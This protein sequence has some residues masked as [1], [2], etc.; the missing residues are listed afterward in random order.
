MRQGAF[1]G[2]R[3]EKARLYNGY[4]IKELAEKIECSRQTISGYENG[5]ESNPDF[6]IINKLSE[7]LDF[8]VQFFYEHSLDYKIGSTYFRAQL[9]TKGRYRKQQVEKMALMSAV[10]SFIG[11]YINFPK[12]E[13]LHFDTAETPEE[14]AM[15]L[16]SH[17][18]LGEKPIDNIVFMA[19]SKGIVVTKFVSESSTIDACSQMVNVGDDC[20]FLIGYSDNKQSAARIHFD[21]AHELG[22][23]LMHEFCEDVDA[24]TKDEFRERETE[25]HAF[26]AAFLL[27]KNSF[28]RDIVNLPF[29]IPHY[30]QLKRKWK[31]SIAAMARRAHGLGVVSY[32]EYQ[33]MM[34]TLQRRGLRKDEPLDDELTTSSPKLLRSAIQML[35]NENVFTARE[36][37]DEMSYSHNLTLT[38]NKI[39]ELLNLPKGTLH[40]EPLSHKLRLLK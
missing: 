38:P 20:V 40:F 14:L 29:T 19:E 35:L 22:H 17:W 3:L 33:N 34:R 6:N 31:T 24:L 32:D 12:F 1:N 7:L 10:Y 4:T 18:G 21:I 30:T 26:A 27:P 23:I 11:K 39:E 37:I 5:K 15:A 36:F 8:P 16:R 28:Y 13:P 25:A 2:S 9:T